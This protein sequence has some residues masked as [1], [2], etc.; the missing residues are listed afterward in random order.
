LTGFSLSIV[1]MGFLMVWS[2]LRALGFMLPFRTG[3]DN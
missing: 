2:F 1:K 3:H